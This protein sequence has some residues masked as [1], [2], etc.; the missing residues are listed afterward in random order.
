[1]WATPAD[2]ANLGSG[3]T[4]LGKA[5]EDPPHEVHRL[6]IN[7]VDEC[8]AEV[9]VAIEVA[10]QVHEVIATL[11]A[12]L[13]QKFEQH[14]SRVIVRQVSQHY[15]GLAAHLRR[16]PVGPRRL[17]LK[18]VLFNRHRLPLRGLLRVGDVSASA[19][20][21]LAVA[22]W[23]IDLWV[24]GASLACKVRL[25]L[26][27]LP[28]SLHHALAVVEHLEKSSANHHAL[29]V[30][31]LLIGHGGLH[32]GR[33]NAGR[34]RPVDGLLVA[35]VADHCAVYVTVVMHTAAQQLDSRHS[36]PGRCVARHRPL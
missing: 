2:L 26:S 17:L 31:G 30:L 5:I 1:M 19:L 4:P 11:H 23:L 36:Q 32:S 16:L 15:G 9:G 6:A 14:V 27:H 21:L 33:R 29:E 12:S 25:G 20:L 13:V 28:I 3:K 24:L 18:A 35:A 34:N 7:Q 22:A 10:G 8:I